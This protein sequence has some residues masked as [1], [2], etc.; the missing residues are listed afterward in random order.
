MPETK[1]HAFT[2]WHNS[3]YPEKVKRGK[4]EKKAK[5]GTW[6]KNWVDKKGEGREKFIK[7]ERK[8]ELMISILVSPIQAGKDLGKGGNLSLD[9]RQDE[10]VLPAHQFPR[11]CA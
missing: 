2:I 4:E 6:R 10:A 3:L 9:F 5:T 1:F 8:K 7:K 11:A